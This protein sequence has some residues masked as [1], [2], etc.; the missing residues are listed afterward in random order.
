MRTGRHLVAAKAKRLDLYRVRKT[1]QGALLQGQHKCR[2]PPLPLNAPATSSST[3]RLGLRRVRTAR[4]RWRVRRTREPLLGQ[5]RQERRPR[6]G[7]EQRPQLMVAALLVFD[8]P[9]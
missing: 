5:S 7:A 2:V 3:C 8:E 9:Q 1:V 6:K 4:C